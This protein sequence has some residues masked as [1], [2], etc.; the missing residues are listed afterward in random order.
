MALLF[1]WLKTCQSIFASGLHAQLGRRRDHSLTAAHSSRVALYQ[2][3]VQPTKLFVGPLA[4]LTT[5]PFAWVSAFYE[6]ATVLGAGEGIREFLSRS[7]RL[8]RFSPRQNHG[9]LA[10]YLLLLAIVFFNVGVL[11]VLGPQLLK[12]FTGVETVFTRSQAGIFNTTFFAVV[13]SLTYLLCNP[14]LKA[15]YALRCFY[16][17]SVRS[18]ADLT[19]ELRALPRPT[20]ALAA[21][22]DW[23]P[24]HLPLARLRAPESD[25]P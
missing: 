1:V 12:M 23:L 6:N 24:Q 10:I 21:L 3:I 14:L 19:A 11:V 17:E 2:A 13:G 25:A 20:A 15:I 18:G 9:A 5:I 16:A 22:A 8:A 7:W 4:A